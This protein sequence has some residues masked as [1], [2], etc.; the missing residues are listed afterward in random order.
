MAVIEVEA[1]IAS[2]LTELAALAER[3]G[4][5]VDLSAFAEVPGHHL[6][7]EADYDDDELLNSARTAALA[8]A[9][10][11]RDDHEPDLPDLHE[12]DLIELA[13]AIRIGDR[14]AAE[15]AL[16]RLYRDYPAAQAWIDRGRY[17]RK[18]R[19]AA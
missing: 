14:G 18:A 5:E 10:S 7:I 6:T 8:Q 11:D 19:L 15:G 4:L 17:G 3:M 13:E 12:G 2:I 1:H 9:L 16:D